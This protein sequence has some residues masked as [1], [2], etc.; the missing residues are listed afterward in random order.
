M[1]VIVWV[2]AATAVMLLCI[3]R[4]LTRL[5]V[6]PP[7]APADTA[8]A[9]GAG[10][11]DTLFRGEGESFESGLQESDIQLEQHYYVFL[12]F[13]G[14][15]TRDNFADVLY[16]HMVTAELRVF[17]DDDGLPNDVQIDTLLDAISRSEI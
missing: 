14:K 15:D 9:R 17:K 11:R 4:W 6:K 8:E 13:R 2:A 7:N 5:L 10:D 1:A 3:Y 16:Y 12:S